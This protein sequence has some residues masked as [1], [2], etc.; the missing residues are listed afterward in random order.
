M[1][2][3][4]KRGPRW[5]AADNQTL[6]QL[7][8]RKSIDA[9]AKELGRSVCAIQAR[10]IRLRLGPASRGLMTMKEFME[11]TGY[12][13]RRVLNAAVRLNIRFRR[14]FR[15]S[16]RKRKKNTPRRIIISTEQ[17]V[18]LLEFL[19]KVPDGE[20]LFSG[21][22]TMSPAAEWGTGRKPPACLGCQSTNKPHCARGR[23]ASCYMTFWRNERS[24]GTG[25]RPD[26]CQGCGTDSAAYHAAGL[27]SSCYFDPHHT[28]Q[29]R[30]RGLAKAAA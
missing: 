7:W 28:A 20:K 29:R 18:R 5:T 30:A 2:A 11:Q 12:C 21:K 3:F 14:L 19:A 1:A 23:C 15:T 16:A 10:A 26:S 24:W 9:I 6:A 22:G 27:C 13:R 25:D 8:G 17:Q 4:V